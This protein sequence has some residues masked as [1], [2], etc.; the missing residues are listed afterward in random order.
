MPIENCAK[1]SLRKIFVLKILKPLIQELWVRCCSRAKWQWFHFTEIAWCNA[2]PFS[3]TKWNLDGRSTYKNE[4]IT[5]DVET[6]FTNNSNVRIIQ[7]LRTEKMRIISQLWN[8]KNFN[9]QSSA[10]MVRNI[11]LTCV[12]SL[13]TFLELFMSKI[14]NWDLFSGN[15]F[16]LK[17][18][19][20]H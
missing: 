2:N 16:P 1:I 3:G 6:H 18:S 12:S 10:M 14:N 20:R 9:D 17:F 19:Q 15:K 5:R 4:K 11:M 13:S 8:K 7:M